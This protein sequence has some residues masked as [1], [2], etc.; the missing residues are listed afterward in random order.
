MYYLTVSALCNLYLR[1]S[2]V[3]KKKFLNSSLHVN[4][5]LACIKQ[6]N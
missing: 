3:R 2:Q 5:S 1:D 4:N 6:M